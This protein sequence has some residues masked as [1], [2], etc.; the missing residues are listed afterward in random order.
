M[1][2]E[3]DKDEAVAGE[4]QRP[5]LCAI[6]L[7]RSGSCRNASRRRL[8]FLAASLMTDFASVSTH[9][10]L[11]RVFVGIKDDISFQPACTPSWC[12]GPPGLHDRL[13]A[14]NAVLPCRLGR[15]LVEFVIRPLKSPKMQ[16]ERR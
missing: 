13:F 8:S 16:G 9:D 7:L 3:F 6:Q 12:P 14:G 4:Q 5:D 11:R 1:P 10:S 15:G 2:L